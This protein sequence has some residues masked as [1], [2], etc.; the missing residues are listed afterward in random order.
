[1]ETLQDYIK[2]QITAMNE[3]RQ[4][5]LLYFIAQYANFGR[6]NPRTHRVLGFKEVDAEAW[7]TA[8][9]T[10]QPN[11]TPEN[12]RYA[13]EQ[14]KDMIKDYDK[15]LIKEADKKRTDKKAAREAKAAEKEQEKKSKELQK[16]MLAELPGCV[17]AYANERY[18]ADIDTGIIY[19]SESGGERGDYD[20]MQDLSETFSM[21]KLLADG[22]EI[23]FTTWQSILKTAVRML[24][25]VSV[26]ARH[27]EKLASSYTKADAKAIGRLLQKYYVDNPQ[28]IAVFAA[29]MVAAAKRACTPT[30]YQF[31][32]LLCLGGVQGS[33]KTYLVKGMQKALV[34]SSPVPAEWHSIGKYGSGDLNELRSRA[35]FI[36]IDECGR[37]MGMPESALE[38]KAAVSDTGS[39]SRAAYALSAKTRT[40]R[41]VFVVTTNANNVFPPA[42]GQGRRYYY[43]TFPVEYNPATC[44]AAH[45]VTAKDF[46]AAAREAAHLAVEGKFDPQTYVLENRRIMCESYLKHCALS[47]VATNMQVIIDTLCERGLEKLEISLKKFAT[48]TEST[49]TITLKCADGNNII[50]MGFRKRTR[51]PKDEI[52]K[53][54]GADAITEENT[55]QYWHDKLY[56][57]LAGF[58]MSEK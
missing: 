21:P 24:P 42:D 22:L 51:N 54:F 37:I 34:P 27:I 56:A 48:C 15:L 3:Q 47:Q 2:G 28:D 33:G 25:R 53:I 58:D 17:Q 10:G 12:M 31:D 40:T 14:Y 6:S 32:G 39:V 44:D 11:Y 16:Q 23:G 35:G 49:G 29:F 50:N 19:A 5:S 18:Y 52:L 38:L 45:R 43:I 36:T 41:N 46:E 8:R 7:T 20:V 4:G 55:V 26:Y 1:M 30:P 9:E 13:F 57:Y